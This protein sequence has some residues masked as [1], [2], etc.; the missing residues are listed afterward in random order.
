M[1][2]WISGP[3]LTAVF[4]SIPIA[5]DAQSSPW[6]GEITPYLWAAGIDGDLTVRGQSAD[7][8]VGFDD[9]FDKTDVAGSVTVRVFHNRILFYG[10]LDYFDL[11]TNEVETSGGTATFDGSLDSEVTIWTLGVGYKFDGWSE[12]QTI[13]V[14]A[15]ARQA[16]IDTDLTLDTLGKFSRDR[17]VTDAVLGVIPRFQLSRNWAF[18]PNLGIGAGDSDL[19]YELW[20]QFQY[21]HNNLNARIG[22]RRLYYDIKNDDDNE[23]DA[24]FHGLTVGLGFRW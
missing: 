13:S 16:S 15:G 3:V 7:V 4:L 21:G 5:A 18:N 17:E 24:S 6:S 8:D 14:F 10:Q 9:L 20:P 19:T 23:F 11:S 12:N 1:E 2:R 22:Y